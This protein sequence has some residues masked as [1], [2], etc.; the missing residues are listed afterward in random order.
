MSAEVA[1]AVRSMSDKISVLKSEVKTL[2][3]DRTNQVNSH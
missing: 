1:E 3:D 2:D